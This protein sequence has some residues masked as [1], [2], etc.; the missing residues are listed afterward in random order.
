MIEMDIQ[1]LS[2]S[3]MGSMHASFYVGNVHTIQENINH[4][5][6]S[7]KNSKQNSSLNN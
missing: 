1:N 3:F 7:K 4:Q 2:G 5:L 6:V